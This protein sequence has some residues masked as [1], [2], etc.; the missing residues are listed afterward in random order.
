MS[1]PRTELWQQISDAIFWGTVGVF[2]GGAYGALMGGVGG[3][4]VGGSLGVLKVGWN[5]LF[6]TVVRGDRL[7][8]REALEMSGEV[9]T[10]AFEGIRIGSLILGTLFGISY[11]IYLGYVMIDRPS[12]SR[13]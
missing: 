6:V 10:F 9:L 12:R 7:S 11:G 13:R 1:S 5:A 2:S 8:S 3:F 4:I